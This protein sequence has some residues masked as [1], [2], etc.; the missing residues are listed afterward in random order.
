M[1]MI[2]IT[3]T[4]IILLWCSNIETYHITYFMVWVILSIYW[5][6]ICVNFKASL[7]PKTANHNH[8]VINLVHSQPLFMLC[9]AVVTSWRSDKK[10][11]A[12]TSAD[13][14]GMKQKQYWEVLFISFVHIKTSTCL[15][16]HFRSS[17]L[18]LSRID[19][20]FLSNAMSVISV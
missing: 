18:R 9:W 16:C 6:V 17:K 3:L 13:K 7:R 2:L 12:S 19:F 8:R 15:I 20:H 14:C 11:I 4:I 5:S 1:F 10:L